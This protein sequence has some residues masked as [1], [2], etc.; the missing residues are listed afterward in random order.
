MGKHIELDDVF[1]SG[2]IGQ[3]QLQFQV[4]LLNYDTTAYQ[5]GEWELVLITQ[6]TGVFVL[7]RGTS[8]T[9]T[10]IL[11]R[12]DVLAASSQPGY[13]SSDVKRIVG[14][15]ME[16]G[17]KDLSGMGLAGSGLAGSGAS[18]AGQAG[19]GQAGSG[20]A[21]SGKPP[22]ISKHIQG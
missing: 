5:P 22:R 12:S 18:G 1:A 21:G 13:T 19:A 4:D 14:G 20:L 17:Y 11:S 10:A 7:E 8:Q 2:S 16:D 3:F 15:S 9:Y 6:N